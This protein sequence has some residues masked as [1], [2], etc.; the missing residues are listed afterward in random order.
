V[1]QSIGQFTI[2][3]RQGRPVRCVAGSGDGTRGVLLI[4]LLAAPDMENPLDELCAYDASEV[5]PFSIQ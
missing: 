2:L 3:S 1:S 5:R 4:G